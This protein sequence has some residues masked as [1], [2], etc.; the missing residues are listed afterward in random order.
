[1]TV[2]KIWT[3]AKLVR[4]KKY[5]IE[6]TWFLV[7]TSM[8]IYERKHLR[9]CWQ[10]VFEDLHFVLVPFFKFYP[11]PQSLQPLHLNYCWSWIA[12]HAT[13]AVLFYLM[14]EWI[15]T[16][17]ASAP[18]YQKDLAACFKQQGVKF[19]G[20]WHMWLFTNTLV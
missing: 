2:R 4:E 5:K 20:T 12:D 8:T 3:F 17:W 15:Y 1:M 18:Q 11:S 7:V 14:M 9:P 10:K 19:T 6:V 13:F 16:C